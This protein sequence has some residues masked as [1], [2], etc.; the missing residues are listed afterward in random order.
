MQRCPVN[1]AANAQRK[2]VGISETPQTGATSY[3]WPGA[4]G[5]NIC[6]MKTSW[7]IYSENVKY[8]W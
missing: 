1:Y 6:V 3:L 2:P 5:N 7:L 4:T 8:L